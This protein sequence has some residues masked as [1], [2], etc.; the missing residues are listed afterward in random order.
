MS[1]RTRVHDV[2]VHAV[3]RA[4][5]PPAAPLAARWPFAPMRSD[6]TTRCFVSTG[7]GGGQGDLGLVEAAAVQSAFGAQRRSRVL[8]PDVTKMTTF[9]AKY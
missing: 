8:Y 9:E 7:Q 4:R 6:A 1:S 5:L 3:Y 2:R